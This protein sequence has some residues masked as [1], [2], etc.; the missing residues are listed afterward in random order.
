ATSPS[1]PQAPKVNPLGAS[2][3]FRRRDALPGVV[4]L[5]NGTVIPGGVYTTRDKNWEVWVES[6]KRWR[7]IPPILVLSI[8]AVVVEEAMDNEWRWKEMGSDEKVFTG[9]KKPIRRFR[10]RFHLIDGSHVTGN[11]KGQPVWIEVDRKTKGPHVLHERS[12]GKYGQT[13]TDL[14]YV[15]R[16]VISRRAMEQARRAQPASAPAK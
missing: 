8:Q 3:R 9:R 1:T 14:V 15:K 13:L 16:I 5:S 2:D 4:V 6:E 10:W 7:H 12:A 11:V